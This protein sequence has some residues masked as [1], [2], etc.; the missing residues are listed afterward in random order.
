MPD[1]L[2]K[3]ICNPCALSNSKHKV[4][5]LVDSRSTEVFESI[6][7]DVCRPV[8]NESYGGSRYFLTI[9][10]DFSRFYW[11]FFLKCKSD[12]PISLRAIFNYVERQFGKTIDEI[13]HNHSSDYIRNEFNDFFI[14]SGVIEELTLPDSPES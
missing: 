12:T 3:F 4:P 11:V 1:S 10:E 13:C 7:T 5:N 8:P 9:I 6:H 2:S 14:M